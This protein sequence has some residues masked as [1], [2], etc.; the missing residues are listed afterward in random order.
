MKKRIGI[1]VDSTNVYKQL[2]DLISLSKKSSN[3]EITALIINNIEHKNKNL[4]LQIVHYIK[5]RGLQK[6]ISNAFFKALCKMESIILKRINKFNKF[7]SSYQLK[8]EKYACINVSPQI[9]KS[10]L[11]YRYNQEDIKRIKKLDLDLLIRGGNGILK[12][13]IL[14]VCPNGVISF[15]HADNDINR[16][17]PPGFWEVYYRNPR[18]GFV[19]QRL[20]DEL[21]GGDVL[22]KGYIQTQWFYSLNLA[23]LYEVSNPFFHHVLEDITSANP[24]FKV[25]KKKTYS[26][27]LYTT[28]NIH[29]MLIYFLKTF[30]VLTSKIFK[31]LQGKNYRW[32]V[33]YQFSKTW[34]DVTLWR[35]KKI[36]NPKNRFLADPFVIKHNGSHF[37]FVE[38]FDYKS[39][40]G[41][42]SAYKITPLGYETIGVVLKEDFHLSFPYIF[43]YKNEIF[44]CPETHEKKEIRLYKCTEFPS[45]W[46]FHKTLMR[47]VSAADTIIFQHDD[48]WWLFTNFDQSIVED[49]NCQLHVFSSN[50]PISDQWIPHENNPVVF[51][52]LVARNGGLIISNN[53]IYRI[54]QRQGFDMYGEQ[55]GIAKIIRLSSTEYFEEV[56]STIEPKFFE[57]IKGTH[58]YNF[59]SD[60]IVLDYVEICKKNRGS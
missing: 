28:P 10:G 60:L 50:N 42:I 18:T 17:G 41:S 9:S 30:F 58:T 7:Y 36:D 22:Y 54:F 32:G 24:K 49:H 55:I 25:Y 14:D 26:H 46:E 3:Y 40:K 38:D 5:R 47:G 11:V 13:N 19:I 48:R 21:D 15:H 33:A 45:K 4:L 34:N 35:S 20:K 52:P 2:A 37:C 23:Y 44:M 53:E 12:G 31:K 56:Y 29:Q 51:N 59:N 39:N 1:I 16:G 27:P 8:K 57:S 43:K 6:F